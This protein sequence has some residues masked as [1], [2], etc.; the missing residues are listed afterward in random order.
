MPD[1]PLSAAAALVAER[2]IAR[3]QLLAVAE[4][5]AGGLISAS[6]LSV[7]GAS[8]FY[9]GGVVIYTLE[10]AARLLG[11]A[12]ELPAGVRSSSQPFSAY[13][14]RTVARKLD[15][16]WGIGET[17]AAGPSG[18]RYGDP[19]GHAWLS[20]AGPDA[21]LRSEHALTGRD[22]RTANMRTF[23]TTALALLADALG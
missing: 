8:A 18:N 9:R 20:V 13:L 14:A 23:A 10:G 15:A 3:G 7:A 16:D 6:L 4:S 12:A 17:G 2:L 21:V 11:D 19:A 22:D 1:D 5:S